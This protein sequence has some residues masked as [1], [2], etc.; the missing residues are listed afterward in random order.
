VAAVSIDA[1]ELIGRARALAPALAGRARHCEERRCL[2]P[3]TVAELRGAGVFRVLQPARF[4]G[5]ELSLSTLIDVAA[6][7]GRGCGSTAWCVALGALHNR[8]AGLFDE[9]AQREVFGETGDAQLAV[10]FSTAGTAT[11][12]PD[13]AASADRGAGFRVSGT[14]P[15]A[16]GCDHAGWIAVTAPVVRTPPTPLPDVRCFLLPKA[17]VRI[18]D[19]WFVAGL[20]GTG[21]K[22][23]VVADA[24]VPAHHALSYLD[25]ARGTTPGAAVNPSPLFRLP[26][27]PSL[28]L[29]AAGAAIGIAR[30]AADAFRDERQARRAGQRDGIEARDSWGA[31]PLGPALAAV[32][33]A[34]L[35][36]RRDADDMTGRVTAGERLSPVQRTRYLLDGAFAVASVT[37]AVDRLLAAG[38]AA[39][40]R[41]ASPLQR[42]FRDLHAMSAHST[43][44]LDVAARLHARCEEGLPPRSS[45]ALI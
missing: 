2:P 35:L 24:F 1:G 9:R 21:S 36:I 40:L 27:I 12:A 30:G 39:A 23:V 26:L 16:S 37:E 28:N 13:V 10:V 14:W 5:F 4:G 3:D 18:D 20:R 15:Y 45:L 6:E 31:S 42:A 8:L 11:V 43:L 7:I 38:G 44:R 34:A 17:D 33:A 22:T 29:A 41:D 32:D 25:V 19:D